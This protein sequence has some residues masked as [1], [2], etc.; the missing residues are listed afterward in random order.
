ML[1]DGCTAHWT[2]LTFLQSFYTFK[3]QREIGPTTATDSIKHSAD[4]VGHLSGAK[5]IALLQCFSRNPLSTLRRE[6]Q[7]KSLTSYSRK[8]NKH[9]RL[10]KRTTYTESLG[11]LSTLGPEAVPRFPSYLGFLDPII[12]WVNTSF[13]SS[14]QIFLFQIHL[15]F[16]SIW[17]YIVTHCNPHGIHS[18]HCISLLTHIFIH[19]FVTNSLYIDRKKTT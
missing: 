8:R 1:Y 6:L 7:S 4:F 14:Y 3:F 9:S 18:R 16:I 12:F 17:Y 13:I 10:A 15:Y 5:S 11:S 2:H 19:G